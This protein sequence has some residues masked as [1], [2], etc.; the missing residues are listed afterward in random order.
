MPAMVTYIGEAGVALPPQIT[1]L[2]VEFSMN[3]PVPVTNEMALGKF[4]NNR[5]FKVVDQAA[6]PAPKQTLTLAPRKAG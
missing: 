2:G 1:T 3:V 4:R 6:E 5:F